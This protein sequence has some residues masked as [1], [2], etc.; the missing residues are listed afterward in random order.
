MRA[1][2]GCQQR[3]KQ[4]RGLRGQALVYCP[5]NQKKFERG[6]RGLFCLRE[7]EGRSI[8]ERERE[9]AVLSRERERER[10]RDFFF[11][12]FFFD[13]CREQ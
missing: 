11:F 1:G 7:R 3:K 6:K 4:E 5:N 13:Y 8:R 12:F 9:R 10:E 2:E